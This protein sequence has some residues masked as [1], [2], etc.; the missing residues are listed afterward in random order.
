MSWIRKSFDAAGLTQYPVGRSLAVIQARL[1]GSVILCID[2]SGSM[3][4][5]DDTTKTRLDRAIAGSIAFIDSA[6]E[7]G[8]RVGLI[9]WHHGIDSTTKLGASR[10]ELIAHLNRLHPNGGN[11]ICPTLHHGRDQLANLTGDRVLAIFGDGDLGSPAPAKELSKRLARQG[12]RIVT[13]GL[14]DA[15]A[16]ALDEISTEIDEAP[17]AAQPD[18]LAEDVA[19]LSSLLK[20]KSR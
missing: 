12:I 7:N 14:G 19:G 18:T 5:R 3:A 11:D 8:Y 6:L 9:A 15:S 2:V 16:R 1:S 10:K 13:M 20:R 4:S 17:R